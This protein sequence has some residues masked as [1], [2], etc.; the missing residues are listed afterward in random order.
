[1]IKIIKNEMEGQCLSPLTALSLYYNAIF[2]LFG[3][4]LIRGGIYSGR[5]VNHP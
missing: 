5:D 4:Y 1:M 2:Y 3:G